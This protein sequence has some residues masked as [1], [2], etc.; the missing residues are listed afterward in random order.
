MVDTLRIFCFLDA[1]KIPVLWHRL[2]SCSQSHYPRPLGK[3]APMAIC[4]RRLSHQAVT[5]DRSR[6]LQRLPKSEPGPID[7]SALSADRAPRAPR[8]RN[9]AFIGSQSHIFHTVRQVRG[10]RSCEIVSLTLDTMPIT[11]LRSVAQLSTRRWSM[12]CLTN[13]S[14]V[15]RGGADQARSRLM[16]WPTIRDP[17]DDHHVETLTISS[18]LAACQLIATGGPVPRLCD[19][20]LSAPLTPCSA[21][22]EQDADLSAGRFTQTRGAN[23][24]HTSYAV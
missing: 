5:C 9:I 6:Q 7:R 16:L 3:I 13:R 20:S 4:Y 10:C 22:H 17:S 1:L 23:G 19:S 2:S 12:E 21:H 18:Q 8:K 24:L 15:A 11:A 14:V